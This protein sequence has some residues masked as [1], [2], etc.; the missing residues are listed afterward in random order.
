M[1]WGT[2]VHGAGAA[3]DFYQRRQRAHS[4]SLKRTLMR[5]VS[6]QSGA[7][8][9]RQNPRKQT[10][11]HK[12]AETSMAEQIENLQDQGD[13][14]TRKIEIERQRNEKLDAK[15]EVSSHPSA[16]PAPRLLCCLSSTRI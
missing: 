8:W 6:K 14:Y 11:L 7:A 4:L 2:G 1:G 15:I 9:R 5:G 12:S 16:P 10:H 3:L 13:M